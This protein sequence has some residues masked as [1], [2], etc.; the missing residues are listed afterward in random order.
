M[1]GQEKIWKVIRGLNSE[2]TI[3]DVMM[4]TGLKRSTVSDY[5]SRLHRAGYLRTV[6]KRKGIVGRRQ[7]VYRLIKDTGPKPPMQRRCLYDQN[8]G[9][10]LEVKD[11]VD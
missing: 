11:H 4:L 3:E 6:G 2:F 5:L 8:T 1:T 9:E 7:F 10:L